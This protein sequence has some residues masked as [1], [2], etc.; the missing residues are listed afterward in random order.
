MS[1]FRSIFCVIIT[2]FDIHK[3]RVEKSAFMNREAREKHRKIKASENKK[4]GEIMMDFSKKV[5]RR[6]ILA[7]LLVTGILTSAAVIQ[8]VRFWSEYGAVW[9]YDLS[10]DTIDALSREA[11]NASAQLESDKA[12]LEEIK[13]QYEIFEQARENGD[14]ETR[15]RVAN[16]EREAAAAKAEALLLSDLS[17][18]KLVTFESTSFEEN[19]MDGMIDDMAGNEILS[20]AIKS[21]IHAA[22]EGQSIEQI[23]EGA[24]EG[25]A[26]GISGY[27]GSK[28]QDYL[29]DSIGGDIFTPIDFINNLI[30]ADDTPR[31]LANGIAE[32]QSELTATLLDMLGQ[33][34]VSAVDLQ[35]EAEMMYCLWSLQAET[36][37][38]MGDDSLDTSDSSY[39]QL[40]NLAR[41]YGI[42]NYRILKYAQWKEVKSG[43]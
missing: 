21:A 15:I 37:S 33:N 26:E 10:Q 24:K 34:T 20:S 38:I 1:K 7:M 8:T 30:N 35:N 29:A 22:T 3:M 23:V 41:Q 42:N 27:V 13:Q 17:G 14:W 12:R 4:Q 32:K 39:M 5:Q 19:F 18:M 2:V 6:F 43:E 31:T 25:A 28:V 40:V 36:A 11:E 9:S 16:E